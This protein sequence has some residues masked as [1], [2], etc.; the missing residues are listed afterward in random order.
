MMIRERIYDN[1]LETIGDTPLVR[2]NRVV[3]E[4]SAEVLVKL[5]W[6]NPGGSVKDR[7]GYSMI[8]EAERRG[9][10]RPGMTIIEPTSGNTGIGL[11]LV[12]AAKG[13]PLVIVMPETMSVERRK[14]L[15]AFG[16]TI[17]L[18]EGPKGM[19][20]AIAKALELKG[21]REDWWMPQQFENFDNPKIHRETTALE[22]IRDTN[23]E[24]DAFVAGVGTGGTVSGCGE[25]FKTVLKRPV[26]V[27]AVEPA[28]SPVLSGG[29]PGPHKIAGIGP[30]FVPAIYTSQ[31][32]DQVIAVELDDAVRTTRELA[33]KE[34]ILN[35]ISS[36][37]ILFAGLQVAKDLG[38][39]K[40]VVV[41]IPSH[42]ERYLSTL[43]F[44]DL[45]VE[46]AAGDVI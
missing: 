33:V 15:K 27:V 44:E 42:G 9:E 20:A 45:K 12:A 1:I 39:G 17:H 21:D 7:I 22:V 18:T 41:L 16:A 2:L 24:F 43:L 25:V 29:Q 14:L 31:Y 40:R 46:G 30:G 28:A 32:V 23:G 38:K 37:A 13:Y 10:L 6:F 34:G 8:V 4:G 5:D 19:K 35:G 26:R 3:P 11:A 36:G